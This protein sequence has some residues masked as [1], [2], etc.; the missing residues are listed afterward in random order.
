MALTNDSFR[1]P[2]R[3]Y[4]LKVK[5]P[6]FVSG[7]EKPTEV[8]E[9]ISLP[10]SF[11]ADVVHANKAEWLDAPQTEATTPVRKADPPPPPE[12]EAKATPTTAGKAGK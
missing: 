5:S 6:F 2:R 1:D 9:T 7:R 4:R 10:R 12:P 8:G 11:A 3:L